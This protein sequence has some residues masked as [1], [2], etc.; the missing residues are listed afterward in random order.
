MAKNVTFKN[1][2]ND[3]YFEEKE[4][5]EDLFALTPSVFHNDRD[6]D[7]HLA[8]C[9]P[10]GFLYVEGEEK[11]YYF[12]RHALVDMY[13]FGGVVELGDRPLDYQKG[14]DCKDFF[15]K[16][17]I[18]DTYSKRPD[19]PGEAF[20]YGFGTENPYSKYRIYQDHATFEEGTDILKIDAKFISNP[21]VDHQCA[22]GNLP[23]IYFPSQWEG[24]YR[25]KK[26]SGLGVYATNYQLA[27]HKESILSSLGYISLTTMG[28]RQDGKFEMAFIAIDQT[29]TAGAFYKLEGEP[30]ISCN[31]VSMEA[32]WYHLPYVDDGTCVFT[33]AIFRFG[34]KE[35]HFEA[36]WGSKGTT[37]QP[38]LEKHGQS[39]IFGT[40]YEGNTPY[41][42]Q[43]SFTFSEN[44]E[45]YDYKLAALGFDI[46]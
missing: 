32:D 37:E 6:D 14:S 7:A 10:Y 38:R 12:M 25:G 5:S 21:I 13:R 28:I 22:F 42:H 4:R 41:E 30:L 3:G 39:H 36:K 40:W 1:E 9:D 17:T 23:A 2:L 16:G 35:I 20:I 29:G 19:E 24:I 45:A 18:T 15:Q 33:N 31:E 8:L 43:M 44:M 46:K 11:P 27:H 26:V 34:G